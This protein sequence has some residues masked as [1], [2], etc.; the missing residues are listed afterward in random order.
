MTD[1]TVRN[2][3]RDL[4]LRAAYERA[5]PKPA[6]PKRP[7]WHG[8]RDRRV[9]W[10]GG[11]R[12]T[13]YLGRPRTVDGPAPR[14]TYVRLPDGA[15]LAAAYLPATAGMH[16]EYPLRRDA[17]R[18]AIAGKIPV[19]DEYLCNGWC[20]TDCLMMLANGEGDPEWTEEEAADY[21]ARVAHYTEGCNVTLGLMR[22]DHECKFNWTLTDA[23][24]ETYEYYAKTITEALDEHQ[25][26]NDTDGIV[27]AVAHDLETVE[28]CECERQSFSWSQCD[29]CGSNLG[30]SRDAVC[31]FKI[32][33]RN[34]RPEPAHAMADS[35]ADIERVSG[36]PPA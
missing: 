28:D 13:T 7:Y 18:T 12:W 8:T 9:T 3:L 21:D 15:K 36:L 5:N 4:Y 30:G 31:F 24:G 27:S 10:Y 17:I 35:I 25:W 2:L 34:E 1:N 32:R 11:Y 29:V 14:V 16:T 6:P 26:H 22:E 19:G 23:A 33:Y 20:C